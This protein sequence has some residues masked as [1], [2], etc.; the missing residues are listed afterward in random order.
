MLFRSIPK[1]CIKL[2][3]LLKCWPCSSCSESTLPGSLTLAK[4]SLTTSSY[5]SSKHCVRPEGAWNLLCFENVSNTSL[6]T[7]W[8]I[9]IC[10]SQLWKMLCA[11]VTS[12]SSGFLNFSF[13]V[14]VSSFPVISWW[15]CVYFSSWLPIT[16]PFLVNH[17]ENESCYWNLSFFHILLEALLPRTDHIHLKHNTKLQSAASQTHFLQPGSPTCEHPRVSASAPRFA[18][19]Q[20][21]SHTCPLCFT[22]DLSAAC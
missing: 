8:K 15:Q 13:L 7:R 20:M 4:M 12:V 19:S 11:S 5:L 9:H 22:K 17:W 6:E 2:V 16:L 18:V 3:R 21:T 14:V 10:R 1:S